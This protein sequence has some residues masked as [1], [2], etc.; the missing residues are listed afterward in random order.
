MIESL[1]DNLW[2]LVRCEL[3]F[4]LVIGLMVT[5]LFWV[6]SKVAVSKECVV[7]IN[8]GFKKIVASYS[9]KLFEIL[10]G[11]GIYLPSACGGGG[12]CGMC[13]VKLK[14]P[15]EPGLIDRSILTKHDLDEGLRLACQLSLKQDIKINLP[16]SVM[17][18]KKRKFRV[19]SNKQ[20]TPLIYEIKLVP[21]D[22]DMFEF[23]VG[24]YI[25][26]ELETKEDTYIRGY[27]M[28]NSS[29]EKDYILLNIRLAVPPRPRLPVGVVSSFLTSRAKGDEV[30]ITGPY[31]E[32]H[33]SENE[34]PM[35]YVAGG[36]GLSSIRAHVVE[37][38]EGRGSKRKI[39]LWYG[40]RTKKDGYYIEEMAS[41]MDKYPNFSFNLVLS[42][43]SVEPG[44]VNKQGYNL[45]T[46]FVHE[47]LYLNL[48]KDSLD[49][50][51]WEYY[52]CGPSLMNRGMIGLLADLGV[53]RSN[54]YFDDFG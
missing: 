6:K 26:V 15:G 24:D 19:I 53:K 51:E 17:D 14:D 36:V 43:E 30:M 33:I 38:L 18:V 49:A 32:F 10:S 4:L 21:V 25:Q 48:L 52:F 3:V 27:S 16:S 20:L 54:I 23:E 8:D 40:V 29:L 44:M 7:D 34:V 37:L 11:N 46:G 35:V 2:F 13:K 28:A 42:N 39:S 1:E 31:G 45:Y 5:L 22:G 47:A 12:T 9:S 50:S 41:F